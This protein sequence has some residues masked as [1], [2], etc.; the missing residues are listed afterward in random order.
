MQTISRFL[1]R[2]KKLF[3]SFLSRGSDAL[4]RRFDIPDSAKRNALSFLKLAGSAS[5][6]FPTEL[7]ATG[8]AMWSGFIFTPFAQQQMKGWVLPYW[9]RMQSEPSSE[10]FIPH[11]HSYFTH[12]MTFRNWTGVGLCGFPLE[13][14]VDPRGLINPWPFGPSI[15]VWLLE[16][17]SLTCPSNEDSAEQKL[18]DDLP[19]VKTTFKSKELVCT[20]TTWMAQFGTPLTLTIV[21]VENTGEKEIEASII[22]SARPYNTE[23]MCAINELSF[24]EHSRCFIADGNI[25]AYF[26]EKPDEV[27]LSDYIH[28]DVALLLQDQSRRRP[29]A[30]E[31]IV[32]P[33]GLATGAACFRRNIP[34]KKTASVCFACPPQAGSKFEFKKFLPSEKVVE[35]ARNSLSEEVRHWSEISSKGMRLSLDDE[36]YSQTFEVNK[37]FLLLFYDGRSITPGVSTYHMMWF[38]DAAYIVP[39]LERV[40]FTEKAQPILLTYP[41]RQTKDGFFRSHNGEWDSNGQAIWT[42]LNHYKMTGDKDFLKTVYPSILK[43]ARWLDSM[44]MKNLSRNDSRFGLLP[45]GISA[46]HFGV[47]DTFYWDDLW[48]IGG[49]EAGA[50][51]ARILGH[52]EDERYMLSLSQEFREALESSWEKVFKR[53]GRKSIPISP[54]RDLDAGSIGILAAVYPLEIFDPYDERIKNTV[55]ELV[56]KCFY[57]DTHFHGIMHCGLNPYLSLHVAQYFLTVRESY[58]H[59]IFESL[60]SL[61]TSTHTFP[62][63]INPHTKGGAY[64]DGH[65]GWAAAD[66]ANFIR[67]LFLKEEGKKLVLLPLPKAEW[68]EKGAIV[69]ENAPSHFGNVSYKAYLEKKKILFEIKSDFER[70]PSEIELG[71]PFEI[72][73]CKADGENIHVSPGSFS[74]TVSAEKRNIELE[75][76]K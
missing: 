24:D 32:E 74:V 55:K 7:L 47:S 4:A 33:I 40:G 26:P 36:L 65:D 35:V 14:H 68:F 31:R 46:E 19:I 20:V 70:P 67:N 9:L 62:E 56:E 12:N 42:L 8:A 72:V 15:D 28:G 73:S 27:I 63:A 37:T 39:A 45:P 6:G 2:L 43:G 64:G 50:E 60:I 71:S 75:I 13:S 38:R 34:A 44:R 16:N 18:L 29:Q 61:R 49:L 21:D 41:D 10:A 25:L 17:G 1:K 52:E 66:I 23:T 54:D 57:M 58:A 76:K 11:G 69:V 51:A 59:K 22:V 3:F 30:K 5:Q 53:L 48:A